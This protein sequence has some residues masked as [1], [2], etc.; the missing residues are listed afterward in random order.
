M[1][2]T[3]FYLLALPAFALGS[4]QLSNPSLRGNDES[5]LLDSTNGNLNTQLETSP[6]ENHRDLLFCWLFGCDD[7]DDTEEDECEEVIPAEPFDVES[8]ISERWYVQYQQEIQY[9]PKEQNFCV[10][11]EYTARRRS[12]WSRYELD[13]R[14]YS[15]KEDGTPVNSGDAFFSKLCA[16]T[17]NKSSPSKLAVAPCWLPTFTAGPYWVVDYNEQEG[18]AIISGGQPTI[19]TDNGCVTGDGT[20]DSGFWFFT[21]EIN[22]ANEIIEQMEAIAEDKGFDISVLNKVDHSNCEYN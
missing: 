3:T 11:A 8:Y 10:Y 7:E 14:N 19:K 17:P 13:V 18:W 16:Y 12:W 22:P 9:L 15:Q 2:L 21:R 20:N 4:N 5:P 1:F 6:L